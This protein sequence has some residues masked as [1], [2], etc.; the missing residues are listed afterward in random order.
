MKK[1]FSLSRTI[2]MKKFDEVYPELTAMI[3][4]CI[5][6]LQKKIVRNWLYEGKR[7]DGRGIDEIRPLAAEVGVLPSSR[8]GLFTRGQTQVL[9]IATLGPISEAQRIDGLDEEES[10]DICITII[11]L[12]IL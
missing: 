5:Y 2:F 10:R 7:V 1:D 6:K 4:E 8:F 12:H 11:F 3:D 9:T